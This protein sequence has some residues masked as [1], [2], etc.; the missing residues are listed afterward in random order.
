MSRPTTI[1]TQQILDA[2]RRVFLERGLQRTSTA[3][4][5]HR[6]HVSE[7]SI[8]NRFASKAAL[9]RAAM[10]PPRA[11]ID[12]IL[13]RVGRGDL[14]SN[15][16]AIARESIAFLE[17][18]LPRLMMHWSNRGRGDM[19]LPGRAPLSVMRTYARFFR[20]EAALGRLRTTRPQVT[21]RMFMGALWSFCFLR[22]VAG[23][24]SMAPATFAAGLVDQLLDGIGVP[25]SGE[26]ERGARRPEA[27]HSRATCRPARR[28]AAVQP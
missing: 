11:P 21:A 7:G 10:D 17:Q 3:E 15:L 14:R 9:F 5:A 24:R 2:A 13:A 19:P 8:F 20:A 25:L 23:D 12:S 27:R 26:P 16:R 6:A 18:V 4:I 22:T 1:S 28:R